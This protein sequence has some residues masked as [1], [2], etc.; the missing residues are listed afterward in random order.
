[1][2]TTRALEQRLA[3]LSESGEPDPDSVGDALGEYDPL[4][5]YLLLRAGNFDAA[6]E[7]H[8][9]GEGPLFFNL[10]KAYEEGKDGE[11]GDQGGGRHGEC[12]E[13]VAAVL[14]DAAGLD[15]DP[16]R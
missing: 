6:E 1:M 11:S 13:P 3:E 16:R 5:V 7:H 8:R 10:R 4:A 9:R 2:T 14:L 15:A 12:P